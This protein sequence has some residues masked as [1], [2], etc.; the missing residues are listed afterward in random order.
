MDTDFKAVIDRFEGE[1]AVCEAP[2][3]KMFNLERA[4]LPEGARE[5]DV[6]V[7]CGDEICIDRSE[8]EKRKQEI[9]ELAEDLW[10]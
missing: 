2:D 7:I 4:R 10:K 9:E 8:T 5:G 3:R 1:W 6:L